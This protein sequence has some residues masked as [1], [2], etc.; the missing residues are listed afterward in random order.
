MRGMFEGSDYY[1][2]LTKI[3]IEGIWEYGR[4]NSKER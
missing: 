3:K 2:V 1:D 4:K